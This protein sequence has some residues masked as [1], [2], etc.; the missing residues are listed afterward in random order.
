VEEV[1]SS[2]SREDV[3]RAVR[4]E[5]VDWDSCSAIAPRFLIQPINRTKQNVSRTIKVQNDGGICSFQRCDSCQ[6]FWECL[7]GFNADPGLMQ[8]QVGDKLQ[9]SASFIRKWMSAVRLRGIF[10]GVHK[11]G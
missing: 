3:Y 8:D 11:E 1:H 6:K 4:G 10:G 7:V 2:L 9:L 5:D